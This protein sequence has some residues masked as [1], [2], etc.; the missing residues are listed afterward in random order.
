MNIT[1]EIDING[2]Q[3][4][5]WHVITDF[6]NAAKN[7]SAIEKVE[8]LEK[9]EGEELL[10]LKWRETRTFFGKKATEVMWITEVVDSKSYKTMAESHGCRYVSQLKITGQ[11]PNS[12]LSMS[13]S[14]ESLTFFSK[15]MSLL[16]GWMFKGATRKAFMQDL[17]DI[18]AIVE[19]S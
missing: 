6:E 14:G 1:V 11:G 12:K 7:I 2:S 17:K 4:A 5:I 15:V 8:I 13:F 16:M 9:P 10:G 18:K 19:T 3:E